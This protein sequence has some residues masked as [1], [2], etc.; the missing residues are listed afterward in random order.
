[1]DLRPFKSA[2]G[3]EAEDVAKRLMDYGFHAPT[4]SFPVPGTMMIEPT[5]SES[6]AELD[7]FCN[8]MIGIYEEINAII[9]G[10]SDK[11]DNPLK[12]A[13]HTML[14]VCGEEWKHAYSRQQAAFPLPQ[15]A[16]NKFWPAVARIN[17]TYGD[18]NLICTCEPTEAYA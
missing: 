7:L 18:R 1:V 8:A 14:E 12:N 3:I 4:V 6:K 13:P 11:T 15:V 10:Q 2:A 17:N 5:E 16:R 9:A